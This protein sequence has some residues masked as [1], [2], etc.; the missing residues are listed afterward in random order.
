M[1]IRRWLALLAAPAA[2]LALSTPAMAST[3]KTAKHTAP[4]G[5]EIVLADTAFGW[6]LAVGSGPFKNFTLYFISSDHG[7]SYGCTT[8]A[9]STPVGPIT[10]TGPSNDKN[11]EWP[12]ITTNGRPIAGPGV[13]QA[14][15]GRV[16]RKGVGWQVT[17]A[18]HPLY[19]FDQGPGQVTGEGW[20]EPGLPPW[21]GIW[22]LMSASGNPAPWAG[23][24]TTTTI[25]GKKVLAE[26]FL[27]GVGWIR[28]PVYTFSG[29][30]S[31]GG[32][33]WANSSCA[34]A[35][36]PVRTDGAPGWSGVPGNAI[37]E[38]GTFSGLQVTWDG[39]PLY[40]FSNEQLMPTA[41]GGATPAGNG[42]GIRAFGGT[43]NLV[44]NP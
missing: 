14:L 40:I 31:Y 21:H 35:W 5:T 32:S 12:A 37:G 10:C 28:F 25:N 29:D 36:P 44:V 2:I 27:T 11:A 41:N 26:P 9:T 8:G 43:F 20:D 15:L 24:L 7:H 30:E 16:Y 1:S 23:T 19:L 34:R 42:N 38:F 17:Y 39:H 4:K 18:G 13:S 3:A 6:S 33:C 22:W